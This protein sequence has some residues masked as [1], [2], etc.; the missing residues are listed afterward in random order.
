MKKQTNKTISKQFVSTPLVGTTLAD[1]VRG[2]K[3][4]ELYG[5]FKFVYVKGGALIYDTIE[6]ALKDGHNVGR[7]LEVR[8]EP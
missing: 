1:V 2:L 4:A 6:E 5:I 3:S 8:V 7:V